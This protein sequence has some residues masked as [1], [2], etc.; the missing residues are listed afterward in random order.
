MRDPDRPIEDWEAR[1]IADLAL[2]RDAEPPFRVDVTA[3]VAREV[4]RLRAGRAHAPVGHLGWAFGVAT[5]AAL[6]VLGVALA[7]LPDLI[8]WIPSAGAAAGRVLSAALVLAA[9]GARSLAPALDALVNILT[10][11]GKVAGPFLPAARLGALAVLA[12]MSLALVSVVARD[13]LRAGRKETR[14]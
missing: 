6:V 4:A 9:L 2:L 3:R 12:A 1:L 11:I 8:G 5:V 13:L 7:R 10:S 14:S